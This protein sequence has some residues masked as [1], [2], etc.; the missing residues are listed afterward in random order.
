MTRKFDSLR[1]TPWNPSFTWVE[2]AAEAADRINSWHEDYPARVSF[3][4]TVLELPFQ[5]FLKPA[6][7]WPG[8]PTRLSTAIH[9]LIFKDQIHAAEWRQV[10]VTVGLHRPPDHELL[11]KLMHKLELHYRGKIQTLGDLQDW[12]SDFE[13]IH[14]FE[15]GNGRVGGVI[16]AGFAHARHPEKGWLAPNQ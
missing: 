12:Y 2:T 7:G 10:N 9:W 11:P 1:L 14:P 5:E 13:T 16:V 3:T 15:D 4:Q 6:E 8:I